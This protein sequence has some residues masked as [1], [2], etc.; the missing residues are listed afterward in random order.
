MDGAARIWARQCSCIG[1]LAV[2]AL[3]AASQPWYQLANLRCRTIVVGGENNKRWNG[4]RPFKYLTSDPLLAA[5]QPIVASRSADRP[6]VL[7]MR[8]LAVKA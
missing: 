6:R 1:V 2:P 3:G 8:R 7:C 4:S 5:T